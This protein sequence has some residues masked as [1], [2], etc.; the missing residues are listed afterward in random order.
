MKVHVPLLAFNPYLTPTPHFAKKY[1]LI[2]A[3]TYS[4]L[5]PLFLP[6]LPTPLIL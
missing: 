3:Y 2:F 1:I 6:L 4:L 5:F